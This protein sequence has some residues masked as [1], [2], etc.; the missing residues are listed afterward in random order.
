[1]VAESIIEVV[2]KY[3]ARVTEA[4]IAVQCGVLFGSCAR[5]EQ[6]ADS[7]IDL[8]VVSPDFDGCYEHR[9]VD[10]LWSIRRFVDNRIE[11]HAVGACQFEEDQSSPLIGIARR[12]GQVISCVVP[13][14]VREGRARYG[15][16]S[17]PPE[18]GTTSG[19]RL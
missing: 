5:G 1:M 17:E 19:E 3:L 8:L 13:G 16:G 6:V 7:D 9:L 4:G 10:L 18:G 2:R 11:P 12:E 15:A 14:V